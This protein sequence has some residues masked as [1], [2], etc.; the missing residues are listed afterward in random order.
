MEYEGRVFRPPSEGRSL[1]I[2][3]TI[4][5]SHNRCRFCTMYREKK[6]RMRSS[7]EIIEELRGLKNY[8]DYYKRVFLADGDAMGMPTSELMRILTFIRE[9]IPQIN[10]VGIYAHGKNLLGKS[11]EELKK[12][13]E[14]GLGIAYIGLES[15]SDRVLS[16]MNKGI[17]VGEC[18]EGALRAKEA[19]MKVSVMLI[20]GLGG[21]K[22]MKE[23]AVESARA[24]NRIKPNYLSL[25]TLMLDESAEIM[26]DIEKGRFELLS[27]EE[28]LDEARIFLQETSLDKT[29]FRS[30]HASNYL[31][32]EGVLGRD[33]EKL[34]REIEE[35]IEEEDYKEEFFRG[36]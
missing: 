5:C 10:R 15:G 11:V 28:V 30:N 13:K 35:A 3:A 24:V 6:F 2:Q 26:R 36:L 22:L 32:M 21:R 20:S 17:S 34:L 4:G 12:L 31:A 8:Y 23:H 16:Q 25:L 33:K 14:A 9:E 27:P 18:V 19:G 1:I 29:I 7:D